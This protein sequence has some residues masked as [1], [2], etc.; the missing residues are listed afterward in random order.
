[1]VRNKGDRV[2]L[3]DFPPYL[4]RGDNVSDFLFALLQA[5]A[6]LKS[7][8]HLKERICYQGSK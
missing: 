4:Y 5:K 3:G 7:G 1:M 2:H 8:L 6:L